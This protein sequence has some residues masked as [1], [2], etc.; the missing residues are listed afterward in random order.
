M[1]FSD[2]QEALRRWLINSAK[3]GSPYSERRVEPRYT[4]VATADII[5][6]SSGTRLRGR[7]SE[8]SRKGCYIDILNTL[9]RETLVRV[10]ISADSGIFESDGKIIYVQENMGMG[11]GFVNPPERQQAVLDAWLAELSRAAS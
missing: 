6:P 9:P 8:I 1:R 7:V 5:E 4:F 11:I 2:T 10:C 3:S